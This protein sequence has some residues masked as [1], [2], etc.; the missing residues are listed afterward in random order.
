MLLRI[1]AQLIEIAGAVLFIAATYAA[2]P[3]A[4]G[5]LLG[6]SLIVAASR[7]DQPARAGDDS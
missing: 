3:P 4:A 1:G 6:A 5:M 2:Y 7:I